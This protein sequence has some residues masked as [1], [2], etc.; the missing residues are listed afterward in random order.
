MSSARR[1]DRRQ[2]F[3]ESDF[4]LRVMR[5]KSHGAGRM[6]AHDF[7]ELVLV[8][9]GSA[10]HMTTQ[11]SYAIS[12]GDVFLLRGNMAHGYRD[13]HRLMIVNI[14]F[15]PDNLNLPVED[16]RQLPGY[17]ALFSIEPVMRS[18]NRFRGR[19]RLATDQLARASQLATMLDNEL[20]ERP[21][22]YRFLARAHLMHLIGFL[23]RCYSNFETAEHRSLLALGEVLS[24]IER[25]YPERI[26]TER[27]AEMASMSES[28]LN[29]A[30]HKVTGRSPIAYVLDVRVAKATRLLRDSDL[31]V[32]EVAYRCGFNDSNYFSRQFRKAMGT[33]PRKYRRKN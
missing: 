19:L 33:S 9:G 3:P 6:H 26:T 21:K 7:H 17:H 20:K 1:L 11:G 14:L 15:D 4:R 12:A 16:L 8:L 24:Y 28:S 30:F 27:L 2:H 31:S 18:R 25:H 13:P 10:R 23:S 32:T 5:I 22:G 29:R